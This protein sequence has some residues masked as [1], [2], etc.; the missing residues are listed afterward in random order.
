[1][2]SAKFDSVQVGNYRV[3]RPKEIRGLQKN[4]NYPSLINTAVHEGFPGH[5]LQMAVSNRGSFIRVLGSLAGGTET[6]EGWAHHCEVRGKRLPKIEIVGSGGAI[7]S[8]E[9]RYMEGCENY[10]RCEAVSWRDEL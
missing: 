9:R 7:C 8:S 6:I 4:L 5:F 10:H 3:T 1:M 2:A